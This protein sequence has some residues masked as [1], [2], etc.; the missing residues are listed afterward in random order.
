LGSIALARVMKIIEM[1]VIAA[2]L[3]ILAGAAT[4]RYVVE[5]STEPAA[6]FASRSFGAQKESLSR[7]EVGAHRAAIREEQDRALAGIREL[8]GS[9]VARTDTAS[10]TVIVDLPEENAGR[11]ASIA[12]VKDAHRPRRYQ[13]ALDQASVIHKFPQAYSQVGGASN[14]GKGIKIAII[15]SG[16]DITNPAFD[17][18]SFQAPKGFPVADTIENSSFY[19]NN[20]VIVARSY[21]QLLVPDPTYELTPDADRSAS[22]EVGHGTIV[23][24]CAAG[25]TV[26]AD[27]A[28]FRGAAPGAYL[29]NYKVIGTPGTNSD[30]AN[31]EAAV[32]KAIDDAVHDGMDIINYSLASFPPLPASQDSVAR[33]LNNA[34]A[35]GLIVAAAAGDNGH[36]LADGL[37]YSFNSAGGQSNT[38]PA[39]VS[40]QGAMNVIQV[41]ASSN[42]RAFGPSLSIGSSKYLVD[43]DDTIQVDDFGITQVFRNTP[44]VDVATIDHS[45]QACSPLPANSLK[46]AIAFMSMDGFDPIAQTCDPDTKM[47]N[48]MA[49]GAV[50]GIIYDNRPEDLYDISLFYQIYQ[51]SNLIFYSEIPG[52]FITYSDGLALK[53]QLAGGRGTATLDYNPS[54]VPL[55]SD[56]VAFLSS[57][58]PNADLEI[59]PDLVAVGED[60]LAATQTTNPCNEG[61][62]LYDDS[63]VTYPVN[64]TSASAPLVAGAAAVVKSARPGLSALEYRSLIINSAAPIS[65]VVNGGPARVMDAGA[66]LLD[67]NAALN[68]E[69]TVVPASLSF[70]A[71]DGSA[72]LTQHFTVRNAGKSADTFTLSVTPRDAGFSPQLDQ[73]SLQLAAGASAVVNVM[74]PGGVL[75]AGEYEGAIHIQ[76]NN[77]STD[78]HVMYW[79]GVLGGAPHIL[80]D[81]GSYTSAAAGHLAQAGLVFRV[82]DAAGMVMTGILPQITV[83]HTATYDIGGDPADGDAKVSAPYKF[84]KFGP[85]VIAVDVTPSSDSDLVDVFTVYV[86]DP[87]NGGFSK[88]FYISN[89]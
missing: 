78:T 76:G 68:A 80:S 44:I 31:N 49:G 59:K 86:G 77:T 6:V 74:I 4:R 50:A 34:V 64:G 81:M 65:D 62:C 69:A 53:A 32:L 89:Y 1:G 3:P 29:G 55:S 28:T 51:Y 41:G 82:T 42:L 84:D 66:G 63:G 57:R 39:L 58:G 9:L 67:V 52:G 11:L 35:A 23:A 7:A 61:P 85:G 45:G 30:H 36:G 46:G 75:G 56:R 54:A 19:V 24:S 87:N 70:G 15:D 5:L 14:A 43:P 71:G 25:G 60:L 22:D 18:S 8:G 33:S 12:G 88:D 20:K 47:E 48:A 73:T 13:M 17:D 10:N 21:I 26:V 38:I 27:A 16:I 72:T 2:F 40:S 79:F 37:T 83:K